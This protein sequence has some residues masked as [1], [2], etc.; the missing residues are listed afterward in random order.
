VPAGVTSR[1]GQ[2]TIPFQLLTD[3]TAPS[4]TIAIEATSGAAVARASLEVVQTQAPAMR[5]PRDQ[6][7]T[8]GTPLHFDV[9][10]SD[11]QPYSVY[12]SGLPMGATFDTSTGTVSWLPSA[13]DLGTH[14]FTFTAINS[15]GLS[16]RKTVRVNVVNQL[17]ETAPQILTVGDGDQ[18]LAFH[19]GTSLLAGLPSARFDGQPARAGDSLSIAVAGIDCNQE[20]STRNFQLQFAGAFATIQ[21]L[22]P[23]GGIPAI[24]RVTVEVP[25]SI[26]GPNAAISVTMA[27]PG[28]KTISS[29]TAW[30]AVEE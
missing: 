21:S 18:A 27:G 23:A 22:Q 13:Q 6:A 17:P 3:E 4:G 10:A 19:A 20:L 12:A 5:V 7:G 9:I 8:P 2:T 15:L 14:V 29:N 16:T 11:Q 26:T 24:C 1:E 30:V 25:S 28:G